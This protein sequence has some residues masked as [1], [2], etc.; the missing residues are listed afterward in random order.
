MY[1]MFDSLT[2][3]VDYKISADRTRCL[4]ECARPVGGRPDIGSTAPLH[5][6][7]PGRPIDEGS[8]QRTKSGGRAPVHN[9][10]VRPALRACRTPAG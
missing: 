9:E 8:G 7:S 6:S 3:G 4:T 5:L 2:G 10:L 1:R